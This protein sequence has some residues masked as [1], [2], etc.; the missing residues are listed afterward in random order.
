MGE[1]IISELRWH[2]PSEIRIELGDGQ[3]VI[4]RPGGQ[5]ELPEGSSPDTA[6][7]LF[8]D[9]L[10][11][12]VGGAWDQWQRYK[13]LL[14]ILDKRGDGLYLVQVDEGRA[15][16]MSPKFEL[17]RLRSLADVLEWRIEGID[18]VEHSHG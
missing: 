16:A 13:P 9:A 3:P 17:W 1:Q 4:I 12:H 11:R 10:A 7:A 14:D 2:P 18:S 8:W 15:V 5:V 6:A